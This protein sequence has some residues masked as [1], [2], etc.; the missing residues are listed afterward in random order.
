MKIQVIKEGQNRP[1][2][3]SICPWYVDDP[4]AGSKK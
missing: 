4:P 1:G 3:K 2:V